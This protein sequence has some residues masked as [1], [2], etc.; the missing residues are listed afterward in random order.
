M[1][2]ADTF[3][4]TPIY[5]SFWRRLNAYGIDSLLITVFCLLLDWQFAGAAHAQTEAAAQIQ[6]LIDAGL[7]P[8]GSDAQNLNSV[9][10]EQI[11]AA[12]TWSD[13]VLPLIVSA[14]YNTLF[15]A[16]RWQATPGKRLFRAYVTNADGSALSLSQAALRHAASGLS[17]LAFGVPYL[18]I[19]VSQKR[20]AP[21]DML[22]HTRVVLGKPND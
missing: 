22:C 14:I 19:F 20:L 13:A 4:A 5:A 8:P 12:F 16:G 3:P 17:T 7:L 15:L 21:H 18:S 6:A 1:R 9:I 11:S 2:S 10:G